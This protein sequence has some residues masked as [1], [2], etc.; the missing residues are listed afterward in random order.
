MS[1]NV[2]EFW[3]DLE[4]AFVESD[5]DSPLHRLLVLRVFESKVRENMCKDLGVDPNELDSALSELED[6]TEQAGPK[7]AATVKKVADKT[8]GIAHDKD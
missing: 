2:E 7:T 4:T 5:W 8:A 3:D 6:I 1:D